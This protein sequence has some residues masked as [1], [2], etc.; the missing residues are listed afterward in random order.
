[1]CLLDLHMDCSLTTWLRSPRL[2]TLT[3]ESNM[4]VSSWVAKPICTVKILAGKFAPATDH[5]IMRSLSVNIHVRT[6]KMVNYAGEGQTQG[7]L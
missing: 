4:C 2:E 6:R 5:S 3:K 7:K 1:M